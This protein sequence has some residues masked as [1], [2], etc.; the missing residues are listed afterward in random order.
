MKLLHSSVWAGQ[1]FATVLLLDCGADVDVR[2]TDRRRTPLMRAADRTRSVRAEVMPAHL[3]MVRLLLSRGADVRAKDRMGHQAH[4]IAAMGTPVRALLS[5]VRAAGGWRP[6]VHRDRMRLLVLRALC[7][8]GRATTSDGLLARLFAA[9]KVRPVTAKLP[10]SEAP[11]R[12]ATD[13]TARLLSDLDACMQFEEAYYEGDAADDDA[14]IISAEP[15][16]AACLDQDVFKKI[17]SFWEPL[18]HEMWLDLSRDSV[19]LDRYCRTAQV[20]KRMLIPHHECD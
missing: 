12:D 2:A 8:K 10:L 6:Y 16:A 17:F 9:A 13:A 5:E 4:Q 15:A 20:F 14:K 18:G 7:E 11:A 1:W 3:A 19:Q